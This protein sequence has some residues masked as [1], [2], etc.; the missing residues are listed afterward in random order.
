MASGYNPSRSAAVSLPQM[1][2][3]LDT[4]SRFGTTTEAF[5]RIWV[6]NESTDL[7]WRESP[8]HMNLSLATSQASC[9]CPHCGGECA[10]RKISMMLRRSE[11]DFVLVQ[12]AQA[13]VCQQC[14]EPQFSL[15]TARQV[16]ARIHAGRT[17]DHVA[18]VP[19]YDLAAPT[20]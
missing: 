11:S 10:P 4:E 19:V 16:M 12:N 3:I 1:Y 13:D 20:E 8:T 14:G 18:V 17:P 9:L 2:R 7:T 6:D 5:R 15:T